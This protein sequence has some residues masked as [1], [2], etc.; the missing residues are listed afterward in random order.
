MW[1]RFHQSIYISAIQSRV[2]MDRTI[3]NIMISYRPMQLTD[4]QRVHEIDQLS[5]A[6]PWSERSYRFEL[7]ENTNSVTWIAEMTQPAEDETNAAAVIV[8]MIVVW[9][10][11]DEAHVATIAIH[12]DYRNGGIGRGL[13]AR[14]LLIAY[15]RGARQA[16]LEVRRGNFTAQR[17]YERF[18]FKVVGER[19]RYYKDN[20][21]DALL[22]TL[23]S[24]DAQ[25]LQ[26]QIG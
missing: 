18:G 12:P 16:F 9:A 15:E 19:L 26:Q 20:N 11:L 6:M 5:F 8:G 13:L 10:I 22:M 3:Q 17:L 21:E 24:I 4:V 1:L 7:S 23:D 2:E 25:F 14:G